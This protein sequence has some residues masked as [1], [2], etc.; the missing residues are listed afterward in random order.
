M[1]CLKCLVAPI[2]TIAM[3]AATG[4]GGASEAGPRFKPT[5]RDFR[6]PAESA[7]ITPSDLRKEIP[8]RR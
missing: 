2:L 8:T 7:A 4:C 1:S 6:V 5:D 3:G